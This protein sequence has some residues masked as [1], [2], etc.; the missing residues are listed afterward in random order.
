MSNDHFVGIPSIHLLKTYENKKYPNIYAALEEYIDNCFDAFERVYFEETK[1]LKP[2]TITF[3][4]GGDSIVIGDNASGMDQEQLKTALRLGDS[5]TDKF[6]LQDS[7]GMFGCGASSAALTVGESLEFLTKT[8]EGDLLYGALDPDY[9]QKH[10]N[11]AYPLRQ[12]SEAEGVVFE[13]I[14]GTDTESGTVA[15]VRGLAEAPKNR[16]NF[17]S[18]LKTKIRTRYSHKFMNLKQQGREVSFKFLKG[19]SRNFNATE[20]V[21]DVLC[22]E[23]ASKTK[24][25]KN[26]GGPN[27][28]VSWINVFGCQVGVRASFTESYDAHLSNKREKGTSENYW[29]YGIN[30]NQKQ[31]IYFYRNGKLLETR[32]GDPI[33]KYHGALRGLLVEIH[34]TE[35]LIEKGLVKIA[36]EKTSVILSEELKKEM[37]RIFQPIT[38]KVRGLRESESSQSVHLTDEQEKQKAAATVE[39]IGRA[40]K[41]KRKETKGSDSSSSLSEVIKQ[42]SRKN[43]SCCHCVSTSL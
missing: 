27:C 25:F 2:P 3:S 19:D 6:G 40:L 35:D 36:Q 14:L 16:T 23:D 11:W 12:G 24:F 41:T 28:D 21:V 5:G 31:G 8:K 4:L 18:T 20:N 38:T 9:I 15:S 34:I 13:N 22:D 26:F 43:K 37:K 33:W 30:V 17:Y 1:F 10:G 32:S 42:T 7:L 39:G 29:G